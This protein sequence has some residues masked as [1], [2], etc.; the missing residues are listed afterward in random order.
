M[1]KTQTKERVYQSFA[2]YGVDVSVHRADDLD[3]LCLANV[4]QTETPRVLDL[5]CGAGGQSFRLAEA[6]ASVI[7]VDTHDFSKVFADFN[8]T[9]ERTDFQVQFI[10]GDISSVVSELR[11]EVFS[12]VCMQ[13]T[14]HYLQYEQA[15]YI[16]KQLSLITSDFLY[17]SVTGIE[18]LVGEY[19]TGGNL[20]IS[21]RFQE[22]QEEGKEL[23]SM[24]EPVCL[25]R[26][27]EFENLLLTSGWSVKK[28]W[29]S[30]FGNHKAVCQRS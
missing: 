27:C 23:F 16:L 29:T 1:P 12:H 8:R 6:G 28:L 4:S 21:E 13:R 2:G 24:C 22:I 19:Y 18:S 11:T 7:A 14:L 20:P 26:K 9:N 5:G 25:Y 30:D 3:K 15:S 10:Q 17:L